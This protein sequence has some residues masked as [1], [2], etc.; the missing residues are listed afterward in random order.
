MSLLRSVF[1][2]KEVQFFSLKKD[3]V[4]I[5]QSCPPPQIIRD[6]NKYPGEIKTNCIYNIAIEK[7]DFN[8]FHSGSIIY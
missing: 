1:Y 7:L 4:Y 8:N 2:C 3:L 6:I 5:F